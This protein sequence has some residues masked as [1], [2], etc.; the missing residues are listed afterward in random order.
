MTEVE[1]RFLVLVV[2]LTVC[3]VLLRAAGRRN[4]RRW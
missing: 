3:G 4:G 1:I 2:V